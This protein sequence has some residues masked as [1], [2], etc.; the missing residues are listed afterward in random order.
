MT[1]AQAGHGAMIAI[2]FTPGGAFE[3][4]MELNGDINWPELSQG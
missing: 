3:D 1:N 4:V 2:Q